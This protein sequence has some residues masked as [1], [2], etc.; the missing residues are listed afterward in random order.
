MENFGKTVAIFNLYQKIN[1]T[2]HQLK[3]FFDYHV[4]KFD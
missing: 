3:Y 1:S 2:V 4:H